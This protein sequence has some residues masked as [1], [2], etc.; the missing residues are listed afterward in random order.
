MRVLVDADGSP[1]VDIT[2]RIAKGHGVPVFIL[3]DTAHHFERDGATTITI[4]KGKDAV[5]Y[6]LVNLIQPGDIVIS[7]DFSLAAMSLARKAIPLHHDGM[8][9]TKDKPRSAQTLIFLTL[10]QVRWELCLKSK[11][12]LFV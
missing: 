3:C 2:I 9:Y 7:G 1:V 10:R 5:D 11:Q 12:R 8:V 6:A 4:S